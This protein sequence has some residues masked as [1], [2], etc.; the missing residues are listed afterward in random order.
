MSNTLKVSL[1]FL[2]II[3]TVIVYFRNNTNPLV[4]S[5]TLK[6]VPYY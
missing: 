3:V 4:Y 5:M 6:M 1:N 2:P